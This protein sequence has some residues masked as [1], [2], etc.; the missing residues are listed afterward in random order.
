MTRSRTRLTALTAISAALLGLTT[1][2]AQAAPVPE[3]TAAP[4]VFT[5]GS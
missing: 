4:Y 5:N 1:A 2:P 3:A